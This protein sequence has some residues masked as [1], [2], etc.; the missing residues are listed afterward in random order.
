VAS[1]FKV[2]Y[3]VDRCIA[4]VAALLTV[5]VVSQFAGRAVAINSEI[6][7]GVMGHG[8]QFEKQALW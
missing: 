1:K 8:G 2:T 7:A 3:W 6:E 4:V 5:L